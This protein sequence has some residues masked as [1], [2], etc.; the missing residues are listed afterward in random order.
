MFYVYVKHRRDF[1]NLLLYDRF[2]AVL[3][4]ICLYYVA[5]CNAL[6]GKLLVSNL[7]TLHHWRHVRL[8]WH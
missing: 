8:T 7:W 3:K 5:Y 4:R 6:L 1:E 2:I